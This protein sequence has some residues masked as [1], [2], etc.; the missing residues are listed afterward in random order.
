MP[1]P[2][3][4]LYDFPPFRMD[5]RERLLLQDGAA[6]QLTPKVFDTLRL[7]VEN[8][9]KVVSKQDLM[10]R[11]W[12][13]TV[14]EEAN[15]SRNIFTL[16]RALGDDQDERGLDRD[17]PANDA[18]VDKAYLREVQDDL[19]CDSCNLLLHFLEV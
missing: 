1:P 6:I 3:G 8:A 19:R 17:Q 18:E 15:L 10:N 14:V 4:P 7:L 11:I 5:V 9:G 16:R 2:S 13:D 12:P